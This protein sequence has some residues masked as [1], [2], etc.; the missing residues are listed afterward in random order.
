MGAINGVRSTGFI[1]E[2]YRRFPFPR[3]N[4]DFAQNPAGFQTR[5]I[6]AGII[7]K[8]AQHLEIP[9]AI[10]A[11]GDEIEIGLYRFDRMQ[12]QKLINYVWRGGYPHWKNEVRPGYVTEMRNTINQYRTGIFDNIVFEDPAN[13][14]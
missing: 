3:R 8:Y 14:R 12:F 10:P 13:S 9:I 6:V 1:G 7:A 2:L 4:E 5:S 11:G